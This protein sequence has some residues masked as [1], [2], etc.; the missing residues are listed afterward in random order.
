MK[1]KNEYKNI[2]KLDT[3]KS[4]LKYTPKMSALIKIMTI[5]IKK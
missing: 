1:M 3:N 4:R 2:E 5:M